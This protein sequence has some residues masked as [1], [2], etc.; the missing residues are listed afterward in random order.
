MYLVATTGNEV[1]KEGR[2][3]VTV[4]NPR[5]TLVPEDMSGAPG[6][7]EAEYHK[8]SLTVIN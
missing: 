1:H 4:E 2:L 8:Q 6:V 3:H 5:S 7:R